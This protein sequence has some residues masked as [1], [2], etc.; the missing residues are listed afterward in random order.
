M[1]DVQDNLERRLTHVDR[2]ERCLWREI[3][4]HVQD[5][6]QE[7]ALEAQHP[8]SRQ[9]V[10]EHSY[11]EHTAALAVPFLLHATVAQSRGR[12][13]EHVQARRRFSRAHDLLQVLHQALEHLRR[14]LGRHLLL[15]AK[16]LDDGVDEGQRI[17]RR[18]VAARL[19]RMRQE[20]CKVSTNVGEIRLSRGI[21]IERLGRERRKEALQQ[22]S[23]HCL[24]DAMVVQRNGARTANHRW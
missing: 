17:E 14:N 11:T 10:R 9:S 13:A 21:S 6:A 24:L 23:E 3:A 20:Q 7:T 22:A 1:A 5:G 4:N 18:H 19:W 8:L 16:R 2:V 12:V 15:G